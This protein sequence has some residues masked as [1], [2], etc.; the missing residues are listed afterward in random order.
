MRDLK[1]QFASALLFVLTVAVVCCAVIN[2]HQQ[3][4]YHLP[5]DGVTWVDRMPAGG[6]NQVLALH[7]TPGSPGYN[8]GIRTGDVL[9]QVAGRPIAKTVDV[10]RALQQVVL[11]L[12]TE[13]ILQRD[14]VSFPAQVFVAETVLDRSLYY[15]YAVGIAYLLIG[16][17]VYYRRV[18]APRS[19]HFYVLCLASF[20]LS[21]FHFTGKLNAFDQVIYWGNVTAELFA[22]TIFLHFCLVFPERPAWLK[23]SGISSLFYV[24]ATVLLAVYV[25]VAKG[26][27]RIEA[28]PVEVNWFL[29]R[30][31]LLLLSC[32]YLAGTVVLAMKTPHAEDPLV[33]RQLKYMRNGALLG[34]VPFTL[35]YAVPYLFGALPGHYQKM[36]VLSLILVPL[37]WA[38]AILRYRLMD[39][40]IIFQQGYV[41]TLATLVVL[42]I[43]YGLIFSFARPENL[44]PAAIVGLI[45]IATFIFQ[46]IRDWLQEQLDRYFFYKDRYDYRRTLIEFARELGSET[47]L[48]EMLRSV[49]DRLLHTLS[50]QHVAFFLAN[51]GLSIDGDEFRL[52]MALGNRKERSHKPAQEL[53]LSFLSSHASADTGKPY[54]FFE[55]TRHLLDVVSHEWPISV[56]RTISELD[57]TY[58]FPCRVRGRTIAYLALSRTDKG[59]FLSSDDVELLTTLAGYVSIAV[60]NARLY[61]SLQRKVEEYERLKE[62]S[63]NIVESINVGILAADLND[64]VE[65]WNTQIERLTGIP[66]DA[67]LGRPL[68]EL[69][70]AELCEVFDQVRRQTGVHNVYKFVL[71]APAT[72][73]AV[74]SGGANGHANGNGGGN[75]NG[76]SNGN[77]RSSGPVAHILNL[78]IA[79]LVSK[80][81]EQ[82]GRL[83]IFDDITD[84]D[85]LERRLVQA[86]KLSSIGLL[87]A[88][89]AHEVNTPL[90]V[91]STYAQMLAK[92]VSEDEQKSK[93]LDKIAKQT[94]RASEIVNSLLSFSRTSPS[95]FVEVDMSKVILET[96]NLVEH[97]LKKSAIE[98][99]LDAPSTLPP[100]KGNAGKLQQVFLNLFLNARDAMD[101]GGILAVRVWSENGFARID[102]ADNG[103][104][105]APEHLERIYDPF[106]TTKAALKGTGL[107]LSVTYGIVREHGGSIEVESRP[108]AGSRF[109]VELP[110][111]RKPVHV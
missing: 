28:S 86:D 80:D 43:F 40:D 65:S 29:D 44:S 105:I 15:Q 38:Y 98:V 42:G 74:A 47:N 19:V 54:L 83:I 97:Q 78:A 20:V 67:A 1:T 108:G 33:R 4:L 46:P 93:L 27:L 14:N 101:G 85:E 90:A 66:R 110:L 45:L 9:L 21:C 23:R 82:I 30:V 104:G 56:R 49:A 69:F 79:P 81:G 2:F 16:L 64:C 55:R 31:G 60:E 50:I 107:G 53:D 103:Q 106:F 7:V 24:P 76:S 37:T 52:Q 32:L 70:P 22:P 26:M 95:E 51:D 41:Y 100:V 59:D 84:R 89:V 71:P 102:V 61:S 34:I 18:G 96:L 92:Q 94:F 5:D 63:E 109:R 11:Y 99:K 58:Y 8:A 35:I 87:A 17:F 91:I 25:L 77:G 68:A 75:G 73:I 39:V 88:G 111:A 48:D 6:Q 13:Y 62:F 12:K 10:P 3:S 72:A 36:A 57:L